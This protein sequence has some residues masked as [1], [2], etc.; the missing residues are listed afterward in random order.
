MLESH[1]P[2]STDFSLEF[3][4]QTTSAFVASGVQNTPGFGKDFKTIASKKKYW[5]QILI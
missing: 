4:N 2:L 5:N 3:D 1:W